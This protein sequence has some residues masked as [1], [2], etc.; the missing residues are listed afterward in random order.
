MPGETAVEN[1]R[2][3]WWIR[4]KKVQ[5][6]IQSINVLSKMKVYFSLILKKKK[7]RGRQ[8]GIAVVNLLVKGSGSFSPLAPPSKSRLPSLRFKLWSM[9]TAMIPQCRQEEEGRDLGKSKSTFP[10]CICSLWAPF[11][12][13]SH[14]TALRAPWPYD[15]MTSEAGKYSL[16]AR[17]I[18]LTKATMWDIKCFKVW[19]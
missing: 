18:N 1:L 5:Q 19:I 4:Y 11:P 16:L 3:I 13:V 8:P 7:S 15:T 6:K 10:S 9:L 2:V 12:E 17:S 14:C